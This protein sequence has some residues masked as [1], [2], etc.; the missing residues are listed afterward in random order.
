MI[1]KRKGVMEG[2]GR[3]TFQKGKRCESGPGHFFIQDI[4]KSTSFSPPPS[5]INY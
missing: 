2:E 1:L 4:T 3:P 5:Q